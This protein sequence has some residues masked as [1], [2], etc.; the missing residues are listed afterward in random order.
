[1]SELQFRWLCAG[2][3]AM[4]A[5]VVIVMGLLAAFATVPA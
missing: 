1:M 5:F 2:W 4:L 3:A